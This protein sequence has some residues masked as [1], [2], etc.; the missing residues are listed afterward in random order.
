M[1]WVIITVVAFL[2]GV[3]ASLG[4]GGG[5]I[6]LIYLTA[7]TNIDQLTAQG[8]N[9]VFFL[10]IAVMSIILHSKNKLV[11]WKVVPMCAIFGAVGAVAGTFLAG[12]WGSE[13]L[14]KLFAGLLII[15]G[16]RELFH[17]P[18]DKAQN[19]NDKGLSK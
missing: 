10:P 2:T 15:V 5:F 1:G 4:L 11:E 6:L 16:I 17:K 14:S 19:K 8:I 13:V 18:K 7:I 9:L 12:I 3:V